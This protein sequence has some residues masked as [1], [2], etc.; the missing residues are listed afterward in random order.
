MSYNSVGLACN[1]DPPAEPIEVEY[2]DAA[3]LFTSD[4]QVLERIERIERLERSV[5]KPILF[6]TPMV[7]AILDGK[8]TQTRRVVKPQPPEELFEGPY[9]YEPGVANKDGELEPGKPIYG[10]SATDGEWGIKCPYHPGQILWVRETFCEVPYEHNHVP[11]KGGHITIPKY[12]YKADSERDYTGIWKPSIHMPREAARIF[13]RVT[14][15]RVERLRDMPLLDVWAEGTPQMPGNTDPDGAV[16]HE[17]F[18]YLW[19][20]LNAK[21]G[22]GWDKNPWVW[23]YTF[24]RETEKGAL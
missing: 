18:K 4:E 6:S 22:Y 19:D 11:I 16:N 10:I 24:E 12:A 13:L 9:W 3:L 8:K 14:D 21:R 23:V 15:V 17:D 1:P 20:K 5:M 2:N 7:R